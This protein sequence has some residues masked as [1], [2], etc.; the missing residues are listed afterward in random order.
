[1]RIYNS[2]TGQE[3]IALCITAL[4]FVG[5]PFHGIAKVGF[6]ALAVTGV[7]LLWRDKHLIH[8]VGIKQF[9]VIV[10]LLG[11]PGLFSLCN[12]VSVGETIKFILFVPVFF[13]AGVT[14][15]SL[16]SNYKLLRILTII[17][18]VTSFAWIIDA[19]YQYYAGSDL[20]GNPLVGKIRV[21]GPFKNTHLGMLLVVTLPITL[22]WLTRVGWG[23]QIAYLLVLAFVLLIAGV[24]TDMVSFLMVIPL[25]YFF[26]IRTNRNRVLVAVCF[27]PLLVATCWIGISNSK[28]AKQKA[29]QTLILFEEPT[30]FRNK[31]NVVLSGR[32]DIWQAGWNMFKSSPVTGIGAKSFG[33]AYDDYKPTEEEIQSPL[34]VED[35]IHAHHV[36]ISA[37]AELGIIGVIG[38]ASAVTLIIVL[39]IRSRCGFDLYTYPWML[40][41]LVIINPFNTMPP[42]FKMWW[43]PIVLLVIVAQLIEIRRHEKIDENILEL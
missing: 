17:I 5:Q 33:A 26:Y 40:S 13:L 9:G 6:I 32:V 12:S 41:F 7:F 1:M 30:D 27:V 3:V 11:L 34:L 8:S 43:V 23:S 2:V 19:I 37:L 29:D 15:Y 25:F 38:F 18:A 4:L 36:W 31:L 39:T 24:R 14:I 20:L 16:L 42:I 10:L 21:T 28:L 22:K 35:G